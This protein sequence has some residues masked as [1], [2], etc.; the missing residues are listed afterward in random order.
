MQCLI[1]CRSILSNFHYDAK[2]CV[3]IIA[4]GFFN[5]TALFDFFILFFFHNDK[6]L[7]CL[8]TCLW[9]P[10]TYTH[11]IVRLSDAHFGLVKFEFDVFQNSVNV[12]ASFTTSSNNIYRNNHATKIPELDVVLPNIANRQLEKS[13]R[14]QINKKSQLSNF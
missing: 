9:F 11:Q 7:T 1:I 12:D 8:K 6:V 5:K 4:S 10:V 14:T 2:M 3:L 13:K